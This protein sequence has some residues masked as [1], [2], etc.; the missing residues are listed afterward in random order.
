MKNKVVY[1][2]SDHAGFLTKTYL[3]EKLKQANYQVM[4]LGTNST[5]CVDYPDYAFAVAQSVVENHA[6]G[7]LI[8]GS[9]VGVCVAA[10]KVKGA[11]AALVYDPK[12]A[13]LAVQHDNANILCLSGRFVD[14]S[15][16]WE[17][18]KLFLDSKFE[19]GRHTNRVEKIRKYEDKNN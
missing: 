13:P 4:D 15:T 19:G 10:N 14:N 12:L 8:C 1:I 6:L 9:G 11:I 5:D 17:I 7:I 18:S 16:N 2:G 3:V